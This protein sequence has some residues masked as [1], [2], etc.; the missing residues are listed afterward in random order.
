MTS[1]Y[2]YYGLRM[3]FAV[4]VPCIIMAYYGVLAE[5]FAFPL[6]TM[7]MTNMDQPGPFVR[8]RNTFIIGIVCFHRIT[9][10][11]PY[12]SIPVIVAAEIVLFGMFFSLI[13]IYGTRLSAM[14]SLTLVVFAILIDGHFGGG[15][16]I[17]TSVTLTLGGLWAFLL[18][19]YYLR[20]SPIYW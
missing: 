15:K 19:L 11:W 5:Y 18:F 7:L 8:R 4:V 13:G 20:F 10:Y 16:V 1:Q 6:G 17:Q 14:G 3:T 2:I 9:G 12:L